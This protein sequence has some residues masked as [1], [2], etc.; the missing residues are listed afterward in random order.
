MKSLYRT[1]DILRWAALGACRVEFGGNDLVFER[2]G[3][4]HPVAA[5]RASLT[6]EQR[7]ELSA[8][9]AELD[10]RLFA[11]R[12]PWPE[13]TPAERFDAFVQ[14][15][16]GGTEHW[17]P[18]T[19]AAVQRARRRGLVR[20]GVRRLRA[21]NEWRWQ[22]PLAEVRVE[23]AA[24]LRELGHAG[25]ARRVEGGTHAAKRTRGRAVQL[26]LGL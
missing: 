19:R 24:A 26:E 13:P 22:R 9:A 8:Q 1:S 5:L 21:G 11:Q 6:D 23:T 16:R 7:A 18:A 25:L 17:S 14:D 20:Y 4:V 10:A 3:Y 2:P 15:Q 12:A